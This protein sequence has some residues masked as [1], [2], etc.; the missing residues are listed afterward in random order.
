MRTLTD[1]VVEGDACNHQVTIT[2]LDQS[3]PGGANH[4]YRITGC[5]QHPDGFTES[6]FPT[7]FVDCSI[8]FQNGAIKECGV[9]GVTDQSL[10]ACLIDR[11]RGFQAGQYACEDNA[12]ALRHLEAYME[13]SKRR[14]RARIARGVEGTHQ[15]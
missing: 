12:E 1:H 7:Q 4:A 11:L 15:K 3:G 5:G 6:G 13:C 2:V 8:S 14:T 9:N 10:A